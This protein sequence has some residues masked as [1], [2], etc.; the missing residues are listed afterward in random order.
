LAPVTL[1]SRA[2]EAGGPP[3]KVL[4]DPG[5][6]RYSGGVVFHG[7]LLQTFGCGN[8]PFGNGNWVVNPNR[9]LMPF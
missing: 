1:A 8:T 4:R 9:R 2:D 3:L 6:P 5:Q 7:A